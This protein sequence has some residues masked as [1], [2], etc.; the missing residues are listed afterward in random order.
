MSLIKLTKR[1]EGEHEAQTL[2]VM[3]Y[4]ERTKGRIKVSGA[5]GQEF[6]IFLER[7]KPLRSGECL[8]ADDGLVVKVEAKPERLVEAK[9]EDW[10]TFSRCCYHLGNRH[11]PIEIHALTLYFQEDKV[12][13][14]MLLGLGMTTTIVDKGFQ[15]EQGAYHH[16]H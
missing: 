7:G 10:E 11:V 14:D 1:L 15:P 2:I 4:Q 5:N 3:D 6:G 12:L 8:A 9:A 13:E 16:A